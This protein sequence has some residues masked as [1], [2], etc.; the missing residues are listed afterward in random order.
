MKRWFFPAALAL[1]LISANHAH[2]KSTWTQLTTK[3]VGS[4]HLSFGIAVKDV[5]QLRE[6][7]VTIKPKTH[8][9]SPFLD[10]HL[11]IYHSKKQ[12]ASC[13]IAVIRRAGQ[14]VYRFQVSPEYLQKS[15]FTFAEMGHAQGQPMPSGDFYWF[16][17]KEFIPS[18]R[19]EEDKSSK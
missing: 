16:Y 13:S 7:R 6:F 19:G 17:L 14:A 1:A 3:N 8:Q 10:G 9:L 11:A 4:H 2:A 15:K 12:V 5:G 18:A